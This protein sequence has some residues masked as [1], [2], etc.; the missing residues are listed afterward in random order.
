MTVPKRLIRYLVR[1]SRTQ[2]ESIL[3]IQG[4]RLVGI[5][6]GQTQTYYYQSNRLLLSLYVLLS[7][8]LILAFGLRILMLWYGYRYVSYAEAAAMLAEQG[9]TRVN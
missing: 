5:R 2:D 7:L 8:L 4:N 6:D 3:Y 9:A 1:A